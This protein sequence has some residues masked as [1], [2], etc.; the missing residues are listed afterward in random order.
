MQYKVVTKKE[1]NP[2][3]CHSIVE[4]EGFLLDLLVFNTE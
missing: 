4:M 2:V 3:D 1:V